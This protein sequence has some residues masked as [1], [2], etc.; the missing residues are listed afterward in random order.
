M[1]INNDR[2][3]LIK[4][5]S[6]YNRMIDAMFE[7]ADIK[8]FTECR[9]PKIVNFFSKNTLQKSFGPV[10]NYFIKKKYDLY[11]FV[12]SLNTNEKNYL[13]FLNS[14]FH[15]SK[16]PIEIMRYYKEIIPDSTFVLLYI[17]IISHPVSWHANKLRE[18]GI[19]DLVYTVDKNDAKKYDLRFTRTPYSLK[20]SY[21]NIKATK[22]MYFCGVT[23]DR[24]K[25][26]LSIIDMAKIND[27][28]ISMDIYC[29]KSERTDFEE[30]QCVN[31]LDDYVSYDGLLKNT[32]QSQCVLDLVQG[33]QTALTL[34]PYE[35]VV[36]NRKLLTNNRSILDFEFYDAKYMQYFENVEDI[37]WEWVKNPI[38]IDYKYKGE[39]APHKFLN[40]IKEDIG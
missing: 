38:N 22:D 8:C 10:M 12:S 28:D 19:F 21:A 17:D 1:D 35:A 5:E 25:T 14:S 16:Y 11:D 27:I 37:D 9:P 18:A 13:I 39:F 33:G 7:D 2:F 30:K 15:K 23:K 26:I 31:L 34:R 36:Y 32:L 29:N 20:E 24:G 40:K 3:Y 6:K 4:E